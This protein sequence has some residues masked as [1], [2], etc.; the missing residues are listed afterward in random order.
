MK[1]LTYVA[2]P[3]PAQDEKRARL[4]FA[5]LPHRCNDGYTRWLETIRVFEQY[6][7]QVDSEGEGY[8]AWEKIGY[9]S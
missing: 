9:G 5:F 6:R 3:L 1:W 8:M 4:I 7:H 2:P